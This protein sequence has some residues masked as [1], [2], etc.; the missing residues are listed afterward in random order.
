MVFSAVKIVPVYVVNYELQDSIE[1]AARFAI[2]NRK[3]PEDLQNE[4]YKK[5]QQLGINAT[6]KDI[7]VQMTTDG[8]VAINLSYSVPI[9][10]PGYQLELHFNPHADNRSI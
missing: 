3:T 1:T 6:L 9:N 2:A 4:V 5:I 10:L 7:H 8:Y